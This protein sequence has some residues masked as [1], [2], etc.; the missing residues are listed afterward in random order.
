MKKLPFT[1]LVVLM[2]CFLLTGCGVKEKIE[3]KVGEKIMEEVVEKAVGDENTKVDIDGEKIT[4]QGKDGEKI[5]LGGSE[6]PDITYLP[7]FKKGNI[8]SA[9][10]DGQGNAMIILEKVEQKDYEEYVE[11]IKNDFPEEAKEMQVEEYLL[12][13]GKN[14]EGQMVAIQYFINDN[15]LTIIGNS[16]SE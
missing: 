2:A 12:Y 8:I 16:E 13:E 3:Q 6:W 7:E 5:T 1:L 4:V 11:R 10:S 14:A 15:S 9:T